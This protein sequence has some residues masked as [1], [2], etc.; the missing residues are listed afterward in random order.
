MAVFMWLVG[1]N[2]TSSI[3]FATPQDQGGYGFNGKAMG[4]L[5]FAPMLGISFGEVFG[6]FFN[7]F[8]AVRGIR[9]HGGIFV[10]EYRLPTVYVGCVFM[11]PGLVILGQALTHHWVWVAIAFGWGM[12]AFGCMLSSVAITAYTLDAYP[13]A[14]GEVSALINLAR[15]GGGFAV[16]YFQLVSSF[17]VNQIT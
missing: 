13:A 3:L 11:V 4:F 7:D 14:S 8:I 16:G 12:F 1:V 15:V 10:P 5:F 6:H 17:W 2:Q 9:K